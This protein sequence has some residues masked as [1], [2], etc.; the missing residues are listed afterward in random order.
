MV[1]ADG[2][3]V[4]VEVLDVL[5]GEEEPDEQAANAAATAAIVTAAAALRQASDVWGVDVT[6]RLLSFPGPDGPVL[7]ARWRD[8]PGL[9]RDP[10]VRNRRHPER[11]PWKPIE[12]FLAGHRCRRRRWTVRYRSTEPSCHPAL[13]RVNR[14]GGRRHPWRHPPRS[15]AYRAAYRHPGPERA[16]PRRGSPFRDEGGV[17]VATSIGDLCLGTSK[18]TELLDIV[19]RPPKRLGD[20]LRDAHG[21]RLR[22]CAYLLAK[23]PLE[24]ERHPDVALVPGFPLGARNAP[25]SGLAIVWRSPLPGAHCPSPSSAAPIGSWLPA[26]SAAWMRP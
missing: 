13:L 17:R 7:I 4:V 16:R 10:I 8:P 12:G 22:R 18:P 5:D 9:V 6:L 15:A 25:R 11:H 14:L 3:A 21:L 20:E 26:A 2:P 23:A 24:P 1:V 19:D